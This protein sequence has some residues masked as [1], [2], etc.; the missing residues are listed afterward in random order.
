MTTVYVAMIADRHSDVEPGVFST[1]EAAID[2]ARRTAHEFA[3]EP[4]D[5]EESDVPG[6]LYHADFSPEGDS[7]WVVETTVDAP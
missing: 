5:V 7:V 3:S 4:G 1:P 6:W 2:Y